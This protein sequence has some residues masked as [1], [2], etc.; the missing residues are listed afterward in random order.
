MPSFKCKKEYKVNINNRLLNRLLWSLLFI[1]CI[2]ILSIVNGYSQD[3]IN[4]T[5]S[6]G[7]NW[8]SIQS[9]SIS[10]DGKYYMCTINERD[11]GNK[12]IFGYTDR[13]I[14][15]TFGNVV[16]AY[17]S[18][19]NKY[20]IINFK[21]NTV[22]I[23]NLLTKKETILKGLGTYYDSTTMNNQDYIIFK[24]KLN[25]SRLDLYNLGLNKIS[26]NL[27]DIDYLIK[28]HY[29]N[30]I[31]AIHELDHKT[32][33]SEISILSGNNFKRKIIFTGTINSRI[34]TSVSGD[35]I[36]FISHSNNDSSKDILITYNAITKAL[37]E[38]IELREIIDLN[39]YYFDE[40]LGFN[41]N[42]TGT[43]ISFKKKLPLKEEVLEPF[44]KIWAYDDSTLE[45]E[46]EHNQLNSE[47][48]KRIYYVNY[49]DNRSHLISKEMEVISDL[50]LLYNP[51]YILVTKVSTLPVENGEWPW[52]SGSRMHI[53]LV[54]LPDGSRIE[55]NP[56]SGYKCPEFNF[57]PDGDHILF[58]NPDS[59]NYFSYSI[60]AHKYINIS[61]LIQDKWTENND[62]NSSAINPIGY[63]CFIISD[64]SIIANAQE[65]LY[66]L[67]L[68][69]DRMPINLTN[70]YGHKHN[71]IFRM[72]DE[73]Y[74][75]NKFNDHSTLI[76]KA[77]N[78][79]N[80]DDGFYT[81]KGFSQKA[82]TLLSMRSFFWNGSPEDERF[83]ALPHLK[84]K[85]NNVYIL[86]GMNADSFPNIYITR[87][88]INFHQVTNIYP[89]KKYNWLTSELIT[90]SIAD[91]TTSQAILY[92][93]ENFDSTKKYPV[94]FYFY[95]RLTEG[96]HAFPYP[97]PSGGTLNIASYVSNGYIVCTPDIH[98]KI[99]S[100]GES[101][102]NCI[103]SCVKYLSKYSWIDTAHMGIEGHSRGGYETNYLVT[104][105]NLF[106]VA[107]S[108]SGMSDYISL[109]NGI[110][111]L[112]D[113]SARQLSF[114]LNFQ[115]L[116]CDLWSCPEIF[117]NNSPIFHVNNVTTPILILADELDAQIPYTQGLEFFM[118]L[119]R[120]NK[121]AWLLQYKN[122][123]HNLHGDAQ[124]DYSLRMKQFFDYYLKN[125]PA[126][127]WISRGL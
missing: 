40:I 110:R 102:L 93:P 68:N 118:A 105:T 55:I 30:S 61:K 116:G 36:A 24:S 73:T 25:P 7:R 87:D 95:E 3:K 57:T 13:P 80:K 9:E 84:A 89:E 72:Y 27:N 127:S 18:R 4:I 86:E 51:A 39:N 26:Y 20:T 43:F 83:H 8:P 31:Y 19:N 45:S 64:S 56:E 23:K 107:V 58:Y 71:T 104:H 50:N 35:N 28:G 113:G 109:Y 106:K 125:M 44:L 98:Y 115:R 14:Q 63:A 65:D 37:D 117:I 33:S 59:A 75:L 66:K 91:S 1:I 99:G 49:L 70:G 111:E 76:L 124:L 52:I 79:T 21:N 32:K 82:P 2:T 112:N 60:S 97:G 114:E 53:Y 67:S 69:G 119:R 15:D 62:A 78:R 100:P 10:N 88:L 11:K 38:R 96:L 101:I 12:L 120:L 81:I 29:N 46:K 5:D 34:T 94:I 22:L 108:A 90:Y 92:K 85:N 48:Q 121:K 47:L 123:G 6:T 122:Q 103:T 126:P 54:H 74:A 41:S 17:F 16:S 77:F 42:C